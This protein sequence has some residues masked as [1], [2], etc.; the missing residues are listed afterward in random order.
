MTRLSEATEERDQAEGIAQ[1]NLR[2]QLEETRRALEN[3]RGEMVLEER[4]HERTAATLNTREMRISRMCRV[5]HELEASIRAAPE[6]RE[7]HENMK[8]RIIDIS[9]C[10][11]TS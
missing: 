8:K 11:E 4:N 5:W 7:A 6:T 2:R 3:K 1:A 9:S 10:L